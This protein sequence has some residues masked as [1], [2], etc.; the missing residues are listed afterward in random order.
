MNREKGKNIDFHLIDISSETHTQI[1]KESKNFHFI[2]MINQGSFARA[3][4]ISIIQFALLH[5]L[6]VYLPTVNNRRPPFVTL[7]TRSLPKVKGQ[8]AVNFS[9]FQNHLNYDIKV[10]QQSNYSALHHIYDLF[11][12]LTFFSS[13]LYPHNVSRSLIRWVGAKTKNATL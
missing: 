10:T 12:V 1:R 5:E 3:P 4:P 8:F 7:F 11:L 13:N 2:K 6:Y 9:L